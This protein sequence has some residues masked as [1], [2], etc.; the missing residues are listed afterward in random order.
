MR[1]PADRR[2]RIAFFGGSFDP[3]H[4]GHIGVALAAQTALQLDTVLF[5][6][7]GIQPLKPLGSTASFEDRVEMTQ[8][9]IRGFPQFSISL[10][11]AP[12]SSGTPNY[13][14]E[15]LMRL[16]EQYPSAT[17][18]MLMGADSLVGL[19]HWYRGAEIPFV[20]PLIVASRPGQRLAD[21]A[22]I[23]PDGMIITED[24]TATEDASEIP[25]QVFTLRNTAGAATPFY[26]LPGLEIEISASDIR[27]QA[28]A[29][30][31]RLCAGHDLLP[32]AVCEY[33]AEHSLYH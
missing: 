15:T 4:L 26:L 6:P 16:R 28:N 25:L 20:A 18:F 12:N 14:I 1:Q 30:L 29:A 8:L 10:A 27:T 11:D 7:V 17:L 21:M 24:A 3:P 22:A 5:A 2:Q 33:I 13:T 23:L 32:D 31:D 19:G 9:A